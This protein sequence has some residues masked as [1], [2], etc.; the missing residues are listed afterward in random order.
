M[1]PLGPGCL[2][3]PFPEFVE[4]VR[5]PILARL[6]IVAA[7]NVAWIPATRAGREAQRVVVAGPQGT[8]AQPLDL[9]DRRRFELLLHGLTHV[10][11]DLREYAAAKI[12]G[13]NRD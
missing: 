10:R 2:D 7:D 9:L 11:R 1:R 8:K 5:S 13:V 12:H 6:I 4:H 3:Q